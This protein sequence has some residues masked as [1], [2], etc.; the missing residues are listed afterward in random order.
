MM[1]N[2]GGMST[3]SAITFTPPSDMSV[4]VQSR[5]NEPVPNWILASRLH[6]R[7]SLLRRLANMSIPSSC[8][9]MTVHPAFLPLFTEELLESA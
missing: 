4:I 5:G 8:C 9:S 2:S 3:Y 6:R 1:V 7:R